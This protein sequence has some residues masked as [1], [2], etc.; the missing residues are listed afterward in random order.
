M[1]MFTDFRIVDTV[2]VGKIMKSGR[3]YTWSEGY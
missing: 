1:G 3:V 2:P